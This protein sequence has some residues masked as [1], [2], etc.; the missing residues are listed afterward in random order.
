MLENNPYDVILIQEILKYDIADPV[1][2]C[3]VSKEEY[4]LALDQFNPDVILC[5]NCVPRLS[6]TEALEILRGRSA[7]LPF[8]FVSESISETAAIG[9]IE[10]G[11][12]DYII[13]DRMARLPF[14]IEAAIKQRRITNEIAEYRQAL[15]H[16]AIVAIID[17]QG[18][19]T[20]VNQN[21]CEISGY[22]ASE[23]VGHDHQILLTGFD[24]RE[25]FNETMATIQ[26]RK[27]WQGDFFNRAKNGSNYWVHTSIIPFLDETN[28]PSQF[29]AI[30]NNITERKTLETAL[31]EQQRNEQ[32]KMIS[33]ALEAQENE[34][35]LIGQEL[36]DNVNQILVATRLLLS[37]VIHG[38]GD[39]NDLVKICN[40]HIFSAIEENR[41]IARTLI[42]P[43]LETET[44]VDQLKSLCDSMFTIAGLTTNI[45]AGGFNEHLITKEQKLA[46]YRI[47]QE[48]CTNIVKYASAKN[49]FITL[50]TT[51][52]LLTMI[53]ADDGIGANTEE[54]T[55]G[56]GLKNMAGRISVLNGS[57]RIVS[58]PGSGYSLEIVIPLVN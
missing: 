46:L 4:L 3:A 49:V 16:T 17:G 22:E 20:Y 1:F 2:F 15:D 25:S 23:L 29:L 50:L 52:D 45:D 47:S 53:I 37:L 31:K 57:V 7:E 10:K 11:A 6:A 40:Q 41:K 58:S 35:T 13:K 38:S 12:N 33:I 24:Q 32:L 54:K 27:I 26:K 44:L 34:R 42:S 28:S 39:T 48:Q 51:G 19:I 8:I 36:H 21:C 14:A 5:D 30:S 18:I 9:I 55:D 43:N 56:V